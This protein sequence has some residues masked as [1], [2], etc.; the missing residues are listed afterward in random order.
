[1]PDLGDL[2]ELVGSG[3]CGLIVPP[4]DPRA[5]ADAVAGLIEFPEARARLSRAAIERERKRGWRAVAA[6]VLGALGLDGPGFDGPG[7]DRPGVDA[8]ARE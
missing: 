3:E 6:G 5:L 4:G 1:V 7:V 8:F 2:P